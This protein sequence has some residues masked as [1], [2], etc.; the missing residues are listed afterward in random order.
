MSKNSSLSIDVLNM[1]GVNTI[2]HTAYLAMSPKGTGQNNS[3]NN[4]LFCFQGDGVFILK[5][6]DDEESTKV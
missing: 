5:K 3:L 4:L 1:L 2:P 6:E